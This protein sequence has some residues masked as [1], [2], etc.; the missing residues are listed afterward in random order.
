M[1]FL[2]FCSPPL[3]GEGQGVGPVRAPFRLVWPRRS[4][5]RGKVGGAAGEA[6]ARYGA[7]LTVRLVRLFALS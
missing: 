4:G 3:E 6:D 7:P 2:Q 5:Q 1:S